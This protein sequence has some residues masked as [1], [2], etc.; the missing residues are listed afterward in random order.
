MTDSR[1]LYKMLPFM[2]LDENP[3]P[4]FGALI[5]KANKNVLELVFPPVSTFFLLLNEGVGQD[6]L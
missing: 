1:E 6:A 4:V 3:L 2:S 5:S